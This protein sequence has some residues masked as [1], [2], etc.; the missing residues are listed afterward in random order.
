MY[1]IDKDENKLN[2]VNVVTFAEA[3]FKERKNLQEWIAKDP[4][5]LGEELLIIQKEFSGFDET[6][7][8]L[9]LLALDKSG[10][11]V[12]IENKLD[13]TGKDV[14][15]QALK[16]VSYC[17]SLSVEDIE[18]I[19]EE[20]LGKINSKDDA[21][22]MLSDFFDGE[23]YEEKI[24]IG[25]SQRMILVSGN[26]R[27]EVTSTVIWLLNNGIDVTCFKATPYKIGENYVIDFRQ[28][29]PLKDAEEYIIKIAEKQKKETLNQRVRGSQQEKMKVFWSEFLEASSKLEQTKH[30]TENL[31]ARP[32]TWIS[33]S[34]G[35]Q[36][37][38]LNLVVS[39]KY[40]RAEI[41]ITCGDRD[42]NKRIFDTFEKEKE[43][44]EQEVGFNLTWERMDNK[45]TSR[46]KREN[47]TLSVY[48]KEDYP[49]AIEFL[50]ESLEKMQP[51]FA[52]YV[53]KLDI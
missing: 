27:K 52:K 39:G 26:Y 42:I 10:N 1:I 18:N 12:I 37:I 8:R 5:C 9:D 14:V 17:S 6:K 50:L 11:L 22:E 35:K 47:N 30:L 24:N 15:W 4:T 19:Y 31:T 3:G 36:G 44:I 45:V 46:I 25:Y 41:Y 2:E 16:Y 33:V 34:L 13:S 29:I 53:E 38:T 48:K 43:K 49:E 51:V 7:E 32:A 20:Y 40:A 28:I 23:E 21:K